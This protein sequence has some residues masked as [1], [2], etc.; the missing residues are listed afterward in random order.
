MYKVDF[1]NTDNI[2]EYLELIKVFLSP[3]DFEI[4]DQNPSKVFDLSE[5]K[6]FES[7]TIKKEDSD[8]NRLKRYIYKELSEVTGII[9]SWGILTGIRPEK[10]FRELVLRE[11]STEKA[12]I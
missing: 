8:K 6:A 4:S 2:N 10:L 5:F 12:V 9:P 7:D 3:E 11:N 1:K